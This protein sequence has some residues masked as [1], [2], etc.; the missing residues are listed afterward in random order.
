MWNQRYLWDLHLE[1]RGMSCHSFQ[2]VWCSCL[3]LIWPVWYVN[4]FVFRE[5]NDVAQLFLPTLFVYLQYLTFYIFIKSGNVFYKKNRQVLSGIFLAKL[6]R[7]ECEKIIKMIIKVFYGIDLYSKL[8]LFIVIL[9][10]CL[11][12]TSGLSQAFSQGSTWTH[13]SRW[14]EKISVQTWSVTSYT[15]LHINI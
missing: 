5:C 6:R 11:K 9:K 10:F 13:R 1:I 15:Y 14:G 2:I 8:L 4:H 12:R 3:R 7:T